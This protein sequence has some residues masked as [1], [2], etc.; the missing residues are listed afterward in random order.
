VKRGP[1]LYVLIEGRPP[2][3]E[4]SGAYIARCADLTATT[5]CLIRSSENCLKFSTLVLEI[6]QI[7]ALSLVNYEQR[8]W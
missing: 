6:S 2:F 5:N 7:I 3:A 8:L 1:G 4:W